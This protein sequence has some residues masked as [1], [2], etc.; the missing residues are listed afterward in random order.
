MDVERRLKSALSA[1][2]DAISALRRAK[3]RATDDTY[4]IDRALRDLDDA[5]T[6]L[7]RAIRDLP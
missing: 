7:R 6:Q 1:V 5:E 3:S 4:N 2:E